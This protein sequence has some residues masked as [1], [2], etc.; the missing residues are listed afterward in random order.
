[1]TDR[2]KYTK[3]T[4]YNQAFE[5]ILGM[6]F[7]DKLQTF[8]KALEKEGHTEKSIAFSIWK[9]Q[10]KLKQYKG[11]TR[12]LSILLN[13]IRKY[14]WAKGDTRWNDY[15]KKHN[16]EE[17]AKKITDELKKQQAAENR[18]IGIEKAKITRYKNKY[19]GF[20]YFVQGEF[21]GGIKI[22]YSK[23]PE[24]RLKQLQTSYPDT[25]KILVLVP[26]SNKDE[27][28]YHRKFEHIKLNGEWFK[29][30][31]ELIDEIEILKARYGQ[32]GD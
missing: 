3:I 14:S 10:D 13:E 4:T 24:S 8:V 11:D 29:P 23:T 18:K 17:K 19:P 2:T 15:W 1:M 22:G 5:Q 27:K 25:L 16:E 30:E 7:D 9:T 28:S 26:G 6:R 32:V 20:V 31:K 12:F 21:G